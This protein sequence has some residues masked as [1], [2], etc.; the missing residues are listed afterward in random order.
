MDVYVNGFFNT[1]DE[2]R[3]WLTARSVNNDPFSYAI[4]D[5]KTNLPV[6]MASY[7]GINP[8]HGVIEVGSLFYSPA[9]KKHL[10]QRKLCP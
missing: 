4:L 5:I 8:E 10:L 9:L 1:A 3:Q 7:L 2:F 6:G